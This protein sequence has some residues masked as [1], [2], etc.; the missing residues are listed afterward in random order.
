MKYIE[1]VNNIQTAIENELGENYNVTLTTIIKN[2]GVMLEGICIS[3][4]G[5]G[6]S[7]V[8]YLD[9][10]YTDYKKGVSFSA[11][12]ENILSAY[13][14][15]KTISLSIS[16]QI[17][18]FTYL[19]DKIIYRLI[20]RNTN[21]KL[22]KEI[23]YIPYLDLAIV[24]Y[25]LLDDKGM[26][27]SMISNEHMR[28]WAINKD[29][30]FEIAKTNTPFLLPATRCPIEDSI[31]EILKK[32]LDLE[33]TQDLLDSLI[34]GYQKKAPMYVLTNTMGQN[35]AATLLYHNKLASISKRLHDN[36]IVLPSSI[37]EVLLVPESSISDI[38]GL[39]SSV[40]SI[41][42]TIVSRKDILS[43]NI[44]RYD[45]R[46]GRVSIL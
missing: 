2:N 45:M 1:F 31:T 41:N 29:H 25:F 33:I 24:F 12:I 23:P 8:I 26:T 11:T 39:R 28:L 30:L 40:K 38:D 27:V 7:P 9:Q 13:H 46:K 17:I 34:P 4:P 10:Y 19:K 6:F 3:S 36:L 37:H 15:N 20:Q 43:N 21:K 18:N 35:G 42:R 22:L 32:A 14:A 44:Y 5:I 16:G